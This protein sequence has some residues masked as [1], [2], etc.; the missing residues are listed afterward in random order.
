MTDRGNTGTVRTWSAY[1][2]INLFCI[3]TIIAMYSA[4]EPRLYEP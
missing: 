2:K 3:T 4:Q 1:G